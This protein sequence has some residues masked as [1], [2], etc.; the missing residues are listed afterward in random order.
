MCASTFLLRV[1]SRS[2]RKREVQFWRE[3]PRRVRMSSSTLTA[4]KNVRDKLKRIHEIIDRADELQYQKVSHSVARNFSNDNDD[5]D[6]DNDNKSNANNN[7]TKLLSQPIKMK[8]G[9]IGTPVFVLAT[10]AVEGLDSY[11]VRDVF[12]RLMRYGA[13]R[14]GLD[15]HGTYPRVA[16]TISPVALLCSVYAPHILK[17]PV[18]NIEE[19]KDDGVN[20]NPVVAVRTAKEEYDEVAEVHRNT[21][22]NLNKVLEMFVDAGANVDETYQIDPSIQ[23]IVRAPSLSSTDDGQQYG[24]YKF[25]SCAMH[26][27]TI[28]N[29]L[30]FLSIAISFGSDVEETIEALHIITQRGS[31]KRCDLNIKCYIPDRRFDFEYDETTSFQTLEHYRVC[32][33]TPAGD[34][35]SS[36]QLLSMSLVENSA[37]SAEIRDGVASFCVRLLD[38]GSVMKIDVNDECS[39]YAQ[40]DLSRFE[41]SKKRLAF[42]F[43]ESTEELP[44]GSARDACNALQPKGSPLF[45]T[46][47]ALLEGCGN[48]ALR[49]AKKLL[50]KKANADCF[51]DF[52]M[53]GSNTPLVAL[54][55]YCSLNPSGW[56]EHY[57]VHYAEKPWWK[58]Y[59]EASKPM[60]HKS[61]RSSVFPYSSNSS[62]NEAR[63]AGGNNVLYDDYSEAHVM[64]S[65]HRDQHTSYKDTKQ[66]DRD[67]EEGKEIVH[68]QQQKSSPTSSLNCTN[69]HGSY[70][71]L[72]N[73]TMSTF[74]HAAFAFVDRMQDFF[75]EPK[76]GERAL[77]HSMELFKL[78]LSYGANPSTEWQRVPR[79]HIDEIEK[80]EH[81]VSTLLS[82]AIEDTL[83]F[84][85]HGKDAVKLLIKK[86]ADI[87]KCGLGPFPVFCSPLFAA[88][89]ALRYGH[90]DADWMFQTI[91]ESNVNANAVGYFPGGSQSTAMIELIRCV[92]ES[93]SKVRRENAF[94]KI[95]ALL[96]TGAD[97]NHSC[98]DVF[99]NT[100]PTAYADITQFRTGA[101]PDATSL[102]IPSGNSKNSKKVGD[103]NENVE[104]INERGFRKAD[105]DAYGEEENEYKSDD[106]IAAAADDA[107]DDEGYSS[108]GYT[109]FYDPYHEMYYYVDEA[110]GASDWMKPDVFVDPKEPKVRPP[111]TPPQDFDDDVLEQY[112]LPHMD[113]MSED[114]DE[115]SYDQGYKSNDW[116]R[117]YDAAY[118]KYY[119]FNEKTYEVQW[120]KPEDFNE[121]DVSKVTKSPLSARAVSDAEVARSL[122]E[123]MDLEAKGK[124]NASRIDHKAAEAKQ[125]K[126]STEFAVSTEA[127]RASFDSLR[128]DQGKSHHDAE[129]SANVSKESD[130]KKG[131]VRTSVSSNKFKTAFNKRQKHEISFHVKPSDA[132]VSDT[133]YVLPKTIDRTGECTFSPL[134]VAMD[135]L[136]GD[137]HQ[138]AARII[139]LL[140]DFGADIEYEQGRNLRSWYEGSIIAMAIQIAISCGSPIEMTH[141][142]DNGGCDG[143]DNEGNFRGHRVKE[144][145]REVNDDEDDKIN[146]RYAR[147]N[148]ELEQHIPTLETRYGAEAPVYIDDVTGSD[149]YSNDSDYE[150]DSRENTAG[151]VHKHDEVKDNLVNDIARMGKL[152]CKQLGM[153]EDA[154]RHDSYDRFKPPKGDADTVLDEN[155]ARTTV[156]AQTVYES[157][158]FRL[159]A[160]DLHLVEAEI[161]RERLRL[162]YPEDEKNQ[163]P[164]EKKSFWNVLARVIG[165]E[166]SDDEDYDDHDTLRA[167]MVFDRVFGFEN[168]LEKQF[169]LKTF[170]EDHARASLA[171]IH[172]GIDDRGSLKSSQIKMEKFRKA[173]FESAKKVAKALIARSS[174]KAL[175]LLCRN[176]LLE[177]YGTDLVPFE[178]TPFFAACFGAATAE[179]DEQVMLGIE[180]AR[181]I[182]AK[183]ADCTV[184]GRHAK[185]TPSEVE[186][187]DYAKS[188]EART[189]PFVWAVTAS[190]RCP[191]PE[192]GG[193]KLVKDCL[194]KG[195]NPLLCELET[196]RY[197]EGRGM[198]ISNNPSK[199]LNLWDDKKF[200]ENMPPKQRREAEATRI[201]LGRLLGEAS[202]VRSVF[203]K[204]NAAAKQ[205][206][207]A[208]IADAKKECS[209]NGRWGMKGEKNHGVT[210]RNDADEIEVVPNI[211]QSA[212]ETTKSLMKALSRDDLTSEEIAAASN[213]EQIMKLSQD[214]SKLNNSLNFTVDQTR[215]TT[216]TKPGMSRAVKDEKFESGQKDDFVMGDIMKPVLGAPKRFAQVAVIARESSLR[217]RIGRKNSSKITLKTPMFSAMS[218]SFVR[219]D[220]R[221]LSS[222]SSLREFRGKKESSAKNK[223]VSFKEL[224]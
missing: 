10:C 139:L 63:N 91:V 94:S 157:S 150:N 175:N 98:L 120:E 56:D 18:S 189:A 223:V 164:E 109:R 87:N 142:S 96:K 131:L 88:S 160:A 186:L 64:S 184:V 107:D 216:V 49:V 99:L 121:L 84:V 191:K 57:C 68:H 116:V 214:L 35:I 217:N 211:E 155:V 69:E 108:N 193:L 146:D 103:R 58:L 4:K 162:K 1:L 7:L 48:P 79:L 129:K 141:L 205:S 209:F 85:E 194:T 166:E 224:R 181:D 30:F 114:Y 53:I 5:D 177:E 3:H 183:G 199:L 25:P 118:A 29:C 45:F 182:L 40:N 170:E 102:D 71:D 143:S 73:E 201:E 210:R 178:F 110:T 61:R 134:F 105:T 218:S 117:W 8:D 70:N 202:A 151:S 82:I 38:L 137:G 128:V 119:Y 136:E 185:D 204:S 13:W 187:A 44:Q 19:Y 152:R 144:R 206:M 159:D 161:A 104:G 34:Y 97:A 41:I 208:T 90:P 154:P 66:I 197:P 115:D 222:P 133:A 173:R 2:A 81:R 65:E 23:N 192:F 54:A 140:L 213:E 6:G 138:V 112:G 180:L 111:L 50:E 43:I 123:N 24:S 203:N 176:P 132:I 93:K 100:T 174:A 20:S 77:K 47:I 127:K 83:N 67:Q 207:D 72:G 15:E 59:Y 179:S 163:A 28:G 76:R 36:L 215:S 113:E 17:H 80:R 62:G 196:T 172:Y 52:P 167:N 27:G 124:E 31:N 95:E 32:P 145:R 147:G 125:K 21:L 60:H 14:V 86:G 101:S 22:Q 156:V 74:D 171:R 153:T 33:R 168:D 46:G 9:T 165:F 219:K 148:V 220:K 188:I 149:G 12:E 195:A 42:D 89:A 221:S 26:S 37:F 51:G 78:L 75:R 11:T 169:K 55:L 16:K 92:G 190:A 200:L 122:R 198:T 126:K 39:F 135:C 130:G 158:Q 212:R 106:T